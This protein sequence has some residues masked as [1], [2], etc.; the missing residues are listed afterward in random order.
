MTSLVKNET[1]NTLDCHM[2]LLTPTKPDEVG[3]SATMRKVQKRGNNTKNRETGSL[4][5]TKE[6]QEA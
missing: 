3:R 1:P 6:S 5:S 2:P 4:S